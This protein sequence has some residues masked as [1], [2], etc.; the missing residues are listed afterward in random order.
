MMNEK[1]T[2]RSFGDTSI[3][4]SFGNEIDSNIHNRVKAFTEYLDRHPIV[5]MVEYVLAFTSVTIFYDPLEVVQRKRTEEVYSPYKLVRIEVEEALSKVKSTQSN[6]GRQVE[7]PVYYGG[8]YGEDLEFVASHNELSVEEVIDI[9]S[10]AE[11]L[12]Y[13]IGFAPGFPYLGGVSERI[14]T[15]RRSSP[16]SS[17]SKGSV[18]IAGKQTGVYSLSTPGGWQII[19]RTPLELFRPHEKTPSYLQ[20]GDRIRFT[21]ITLDQYHAYKEEV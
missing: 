11:Y 19:G 3:I 5:G 16:R 7:I 14:A 9:H 1:V 6:R 13:M 10:S 2:I 8:E 12:V 20:P 15:P 17:I 4:V 18:G 21:Q